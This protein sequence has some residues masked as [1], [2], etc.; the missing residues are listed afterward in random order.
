METISYIDSEDKYIPVTLISQDTNQ[1]IVQ[2]DY[3][4]PHSW[5]IENGWIL[6][7]FILD[8]VNSD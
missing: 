6:G 2:I 3:R 5:M 8:K 7:E 1:K 4:P